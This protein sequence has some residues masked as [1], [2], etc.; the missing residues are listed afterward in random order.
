[1]TNDFAQLTEYID[2]A[3]HDRFP[4]IQ[5]T[6][7]HRGEPVFAHWA[8]YIDPENRLKPVNSN[9]LFDLASVTKLFVTA[10]FMRSVEIGKV[11]LDQKVCT[12]LPEFSG[13]R[14]ITSYENP[15]DWSGTIAPNTSDGA[16][17]DAGEITFRQLLAHHSGL[18][19]WRAFKDQPDAEAAK[20]LA[21]QTTFFYPIG[22]R[23][24]YSDVG[25]ILIG[26]ALEAI[27][28][29]RLDRI[30]AKLVTLPL[31]LKHTTYLP[32]G[33]TISGVDYAN[34]APTEFCK[35]RGRRIQ[36]EVHD[37]STSRLG[38][39]AGHAGVFST[40][41]DLAAFGQ[42]FLAPPRGYLSPE[43][44]RQMRSLQAEDGDVRRG[45]GFALWCPDP[46]ASSNPLSANAFGHTGFTGTELWIDPDREL[47][48]SLLT[49]DVYFGRE[50][51]V[52]MP[53]RVNV[54]KLLLA[55]L[56][57]GRKDHF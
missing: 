14:P 42:A 5:M 15:L 55:A 8:G 21:L 12:I 48:I 27:H 57:A 31:A 22:N 34:I 52:V 53:F 9:T 17:I 45:I 32:L 56:E 51:R 1:M 2:A 18:P 43:T 46:E 49:N 25:L 40:S 50:D 11:E 44:I 35:W 47:V 26:I 30:V 54:H 36:G 24:V 19:A 29:E 16:M 23:V 7:L 13:K 10:A 39:I 38:G 37:E 6:V 33:E 41:S 20:K 3:T 4:A 28:R